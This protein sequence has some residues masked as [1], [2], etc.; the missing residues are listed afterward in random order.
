[1]RTSTCCLPSK[2]LRRQPKASNVKLMIRAFSVSGSSGPGFELKEG[3]RAELVNLQLALFRG[4]ALWSKAAGEGSACLGS[5]SAQGEGGRKK[6]S[7]HRTTLLNCNQVTGEG[8]LITGQL[9]I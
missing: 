1:M 2:P 3:H 9:N 8:G 4:A 7:R 6:W 5:L